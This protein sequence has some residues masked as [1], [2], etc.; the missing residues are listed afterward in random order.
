MRRRRSALA[1]SE[2]VRSLGSEQ[3]I[4]TW[5]LFVDR[6]HKDRK[7][8]TFI[9]ICHRAALWIIVIMK[10]RCK[11]ITKQNQYVCL[12]FSIIIWYHASAVVS[13]VNCVCCSVSYYRNV[14]SSDFGIDLRW[15]T[16]HVYSFWA[17]F[18]QNYDHWNK[19]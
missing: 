15:P 12:D 5:Q 17:K 14:L 11:T 19:N 4:I 7:P 2:L 13:K 9:R 10:N 3:L 8:Q 1:L 16:D 6:K 18:G